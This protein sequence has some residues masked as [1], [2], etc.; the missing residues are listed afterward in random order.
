M[1]IRARVVVTMDGKPID[2]GAVVV[3]KDRIVDL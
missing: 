3:S 2:N 1:I